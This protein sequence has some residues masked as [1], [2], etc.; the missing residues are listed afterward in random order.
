MK[1]IQ[2]RIIFEGRLDEFMV[3]EGVTLNNMEQ[4]RKQEELL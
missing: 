4:R 1:Y 3:V 2:Q